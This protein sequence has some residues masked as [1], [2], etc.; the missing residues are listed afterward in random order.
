M[1]T[2]T[3]SEFS[4]LYAT[5][6]CRNWDLIPLQDTVVYGPLH[7]GHKP[8]YIGGLNRT[9]KFNEISLRDEKFTLSGTQ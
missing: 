2:Y 9:I 4:I 8:F 6:T 5:F 1:A 3:S 7:I